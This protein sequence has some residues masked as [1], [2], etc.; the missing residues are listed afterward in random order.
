MAAASDPALREAIHVAARWY[1]RRHS[2]AFS[3]EEEGRWQAWL[4]ASELNRRAWAQ[5]QEVARQ[6]GQLPGEVAGPA[7]RAVSVRRRQVLRTLLLGGVALPVVWAGRH[8]YVEQGYAADLRTPVGQRR[9]VLLA[10]G[11]RLMLDADSAVDVVLDDRQR[12][13]RLRRGQIL[14]TTGHPP[15]P[16]R[17]FVVATRHGR[18]AAL[19]TRFN[20]SSDADG[21]QVA[22]LDDAVRITPAGQVDGGQV[23]RAGQQARLDGSGECVVSPASPSAGTWAGGAVVAV[24]MPLADLLEELGRYRH[25]VLRCDPAVAA[26]AVSGAF[27]LDDTDSALRLLVQ[28]FPLR[29]ESHTRF[30]VMVGPG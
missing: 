10:D 22:V 21:S 2:G 28:T 8:M 19:G 1:A 24:D 16:W 11:T 17:P 30:W 14:I 12:L 18:I 5:M 6:M 26:L 13:I 29:V 9:S 25:G 4:S 23:V 20:V 27:R 3:P 15:G 7:L